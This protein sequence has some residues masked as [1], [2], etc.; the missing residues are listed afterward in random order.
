MGQTKGNVKLINID[1]LQFAVINKKK[2]LKKTNWLKKDYQ[3]RLFSD[4]Y[5]YISHDTVY[6]EMVCNPKSNIINENLCIIKVANEILY[7]PDLH[8]YIEYLLIEEDF[9]YNNIT[10]LDLCM[11]FA[12]F[13]NELYPDEFIYNFFTDKYLKNNKTQYKIIGSQNYCNIPEYIRFGSGNSAVSS[14]LYNKSK[15]FRDVKHKAYISEMWSKNGLSSNCDIW[16]LEFSVKEF[17]TVLT[18]KSTGQ[19][20]KI[21]LNFLKDFNNILSLYSALYSKYFDFRKNDGKSNKSRMKKIEL[22]ELEDINTCWYSEREKLDTDRSDKIMIKKLDSMQNELRAIKS[23]YC[24]EVEA[25]KE[26]LIHK[27]N[28]EEWAKDRGYII[29]YNSQLESR[30][31]KENDKSQINSLYNI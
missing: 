4:V 9:I 22:F 31:Y 18:D 13:D 6:F 7:H 30:A 29:P 28:L 2:T 8:K 11:D 17:N 1:W 25:V 20:F 15:E 14:Y 3:T 19:Q 23:D 21:D 27:K 26:Y 24:N 16:R 10:R 12:K 5:E